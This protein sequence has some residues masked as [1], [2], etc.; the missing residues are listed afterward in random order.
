MRPEE[1]VAAD[2]GALPQPGRS[3]EGFPLPGSVQD[4]IED[5]SP[6]FCAGGFFRTGQKTGRTDRNRAAM[7]EW[8]NSDDIPHPAAWN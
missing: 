1:A 5:T 8:R 7:S 2:A 4:I 6:H 3:A